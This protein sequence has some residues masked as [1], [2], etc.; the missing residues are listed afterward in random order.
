M[1]STHDITVLVNGEVRVAAVDAR[2]SL[3]DFLRD[4]LGLTGTHL[5]CEH[6][7][8]GACTVHINGAPVRSCIVLA[9]QA[10]GEAITTVEGLADGEGE[11]SSLQRAFC[12]RHA[13]QCGFCTPGMLLALQPLLETTERPTSHDVDEAIGGNICRCTGYVQ[14]REAAEEAIAE[15]HSAPRTTTLEAAGSDASSTTTT[16]GVSSA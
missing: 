11:L 13:L 9:A 16:T 5:G 7:V 10:D 2:T 1:G 3:A 8:C 4:G 15:I 14:I 12:R 6:G